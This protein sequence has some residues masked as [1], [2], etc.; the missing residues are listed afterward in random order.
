MQVVNESSFYKIQRNLVAPS[1]S[2]TCNESIASAWEE[3][4]Q[5]DSVIIGDGRF[6]S[7]GK[8]AKYCTYSCQA[9]STNNVA[10]AATLQTSKVKVQHLWIQRMY[11]S[12]R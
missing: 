12:T 1:I 9:P 7:P 4:R 3:S 2:K 11:V 8:C 10:T 5:K 6:D